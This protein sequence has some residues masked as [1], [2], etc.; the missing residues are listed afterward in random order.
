MDLK[1]FDRFKI[2]GTDYRG[3]RH[4]SIQSESLFLL[5]TFRWWSK[6]MWGRDRETGKW[7]RLY[8]VGGNA[9]PC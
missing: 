1:R 5:Q 3:R 9:S 8:R 6:S 4:G 2:T 7:R